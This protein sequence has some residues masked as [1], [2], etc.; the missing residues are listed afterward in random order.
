MTAAFLAQ[1]NRYLWQTLLGK[2]GA[3]VWCAVRAVHKEVVYTLISLLT[4]G[5]CVYVCVCVVSGGQQ[6][7][8]V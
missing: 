8:H 6:H 2:R 7:E 3:Y 1:A 5:S 4:F